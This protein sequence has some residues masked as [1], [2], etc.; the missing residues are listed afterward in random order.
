[1]KTFFHRLMKNVCRIAENLYRSRAIT[2]SD[3]LFF[4]CIYN[5]SFVRSSRSHKSNFTGI[6]GF[7]I[8]DFRAVHASF[9]IIPSR[10][11]LYRA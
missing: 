6:M 5:V 2:S 1:M 3:E 8:I 11:N 9:A 4:F 7:S 10:R